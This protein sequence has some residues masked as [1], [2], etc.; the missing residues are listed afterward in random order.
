VTKSAARPKDI[1]DLAKFREKLYVISNR[2]G[3]SCIVVRVN[4]VRGLRAAH[5]LEAALWTT[6]DMPCER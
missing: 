5:L 4:A 1:R 2:P 6:D 3:G